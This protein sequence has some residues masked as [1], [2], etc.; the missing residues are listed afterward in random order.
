MNIEKDISG[1][2]ATNVV[3][4]PIN[5]DEDLASTEGS[6]SIDNAESISIS[7]SIFF[8]NEF[9]VHFF[10]M[11]LFAENDSTFDT[12]DDKIR[13]IERRKHTKC[14]MIQILC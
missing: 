5:G 13:S 8:A 6:N 4:I 9:R 7:I 1:N 2:D 10:V 14:L 3:G 11:I 12:I